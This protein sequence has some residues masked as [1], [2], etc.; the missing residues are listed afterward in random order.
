[1]YRKMVL[2]NQ[3]GKQ[4]IIEQIN[5]DVYLT[6]INRN[7]IVTEKYL[8]QYFSFDDYVDIYECSELGYKRISEYI[9]S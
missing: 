6:H 8:S 1:M 5:D 2:K 7:N 4:K 9:E 3:Y